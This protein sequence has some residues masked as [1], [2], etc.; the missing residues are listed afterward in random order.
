MPV[1][2]P[3]GHL[4]SP[5]SGEIEP[6]LA[7]AVAAAIPKAGAPVVQEKTNSPVTHQPGRMESIMK[8]TLRTIRKIRLSVEQLEPRC[9]LSGTP[10]EMAYFNALLDPAQATNIALQSGSWSNPTTWQNRAIP[11]ANASV[12]V[13]EGISVLYDVG[14]VSPNL[15]WIR[16]EGTIRFDDSQDESLLVETITVGMMGDFDIGA[17]DA[18]FQHYA[19]VTFADNG[20]VSDPNQLS[21]GLI[22]A[23]CLCIYG[24]P[25]LSFAPTFAN[26]HAGDTDLSFN[27]P[28]TN[29]QVGDKILL[30]GTVSGA[31]QDE[32]ATIA[33]LYDA[34]GGVTSVGLDHPLA[35]DHLAGWDGLHPYVADE[36]RTITFTSQNTTDFKR[37]GHVMQMDSNDARINYAAFTHLGRTNKAV[38]IDDVVN[39]LQGPNDYAPGGGTNIR[40]RYALHFHR[41]GTDPSI[42]P[43][44]VVGNFLTDS[45]GWGYVNH[46]S[47]VAFTDNVAYDVDGAAFVTEVGGEI[48][49]FTH[50]LAIYQS[51]GRTARDPND[52]T[53]VRENLADWG[54]GGDGF[55]L[56]GAGVDLVNNVSCGAAATG[57]EYI[58][59]LI[60]EPPPIGPAMYPAAALNDPSIADG[61]PTIEADK[62]PIH[63]FYGNEAFACNDGF[64]SYFFTP[65]VTE[66]GQNVIDHFLVWGVSD[67]GIN[68]D[69]SY[70]VTIRDS[71]VLNDG[72]GFIGIRQNNLGG[73]LTVENADVEGWLT[74]L[75]NAQQDE[76]IVSGGYYGNATDISIGN[77]M[78]SNRSVT[79]NNVTFGTDPTETW[80]DYQISTG[81]GLDCLSYAGIITFNG[82]RLYAPQQAAAYIPFPTLASVPAG[83]SASWAGKTN[84]QLMNL[85]GVAIGGGVAPLD[86]AIV[87]HIG[88]LLGA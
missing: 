58:G 5:H 54:N 70:G 18:P 43:I 44:Q 66:T 16:D 46:S 57:Y 21:R 53:F 86:A 42:A 79:I 35:Y 73:D 36:A 62:V 25:I 3:P 24:Q 83:G 67:V 50:N 88:G 26:P 37:F 64:S 7:S 39:F 56:A 78:D 12:F 60:K 19:T 63:M 13:P 30:S 81:A 27:T 65:I 20:P 47:N 29:W 22:S 76:T 49:S 11:A 31:H 38:P 33:W 45:P 77:A 85:Y 74:G 52:S 34:G 71:R 61:Q 51:G 68:L 4:P 14:A 28:L 48:G 23:G 8:T 59:I 72:T 15:A 87:E 17:A 55:S 41:T 82:R 69:Y 75:F 32:E 40:G 10:A 84:R 80:V 1:G 6:V 2:A 9:M